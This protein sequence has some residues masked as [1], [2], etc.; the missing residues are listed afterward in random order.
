VGRE[1]IGYNIMSVTQDPVAVDAAVGQVYEDDRGGEL[2][3]LIYVDEQIIVLRSEREGRKGNKSHRIEPRVQFDKQR[4][5][6]RMKHKPDS[7]V[8]LISGGKTDWSEVDYIGEKTAKNLHDAD[9][10]TVVDIL[11]A[12][13]KELLG[14]SGLGM[15]GLRNLRSFAE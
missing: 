8:D 10:N 1:R 12:E 7:D 3:Q 15:K 14:I 5:A 13:D 9:Y 4:D 11:Q 2:Y 6:G